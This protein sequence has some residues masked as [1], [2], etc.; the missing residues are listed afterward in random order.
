MKKVVILLMAVG[1]AFTGMAQKEK[2]APKPN[3]NKAL[4]LLRQGKFDEAKAIVDGV[5]THEKTMTDPKA[6]FTR[7]LVYAAMDTSSKYT[8]STIENSKLA[9][10]AFT[11]ANDLAGPKAAVLSVID[12]GET[13]LLSTAVSRI[14][15]KFL[16]KG[17]KL[18]K[19]EKFKEAVGQFE[20][21]INI[22]PDSSIYQYAGYAS[23][24]AED[25]DNAIKFISKYI[26][27]GGK[28]EQAVFLMVGS[29]Y[30]FKKDYERTIVE[31]RRALKMFPNNTNLRKMELNSLISLKRYQEATDN[32]KESLLADPKD[33][34]SHFLMAALYEELGDR[35]KSQEFFEK[36]VQLDPKHLNANLALAKIKD[37]NG[38]KKVKS[39]MD[40]LDYKKD[41]AKLEALDKEYLSE[42]NISLKR[43]EDISKIDQ[44]NQDVLGNLY[45][46]Y[47]QLEMKDKL[48]AVISRMKANGMEVD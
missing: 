10:E 47:G 34:E 45:L 28:N 1:V 29:L 31:A 44:N 38:Y 5:P 23:Y 40:K 41:K 35:G 19:E 2:E 18:F 12:N 27:M 7:G 37:N 11:K 3:T 8:G 30:E 24:N 6:W 43:W 25:T 36:T 16:L 15:N 17:D 9:G 48:N 22:V 42:L 20:R 39:E 14:N 4:N 21:A 13:L 32:L 33:V 26:D 46:L